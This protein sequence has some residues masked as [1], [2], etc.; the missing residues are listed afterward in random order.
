MRPVGVRVRPARLARGS[1]G[2]AGL[3]VAD[4][5]RLHAGAPQGQCEGAASAVAGG[6]A[7]QPARSSNSRA[8]PSELAHRGEGG[9]A[10]T[11][12]GN[13]NLVDADTIT[14]TTATPK[15]A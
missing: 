6:G 15:C 11:N 3:I 5:P 9:R 14:R 13:E 1:S 10:R 7:A 12:G 2:E 4:S 8:A